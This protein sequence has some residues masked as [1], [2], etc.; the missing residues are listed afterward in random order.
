VK[1]A[2]TKA[3]GYI[4]ITSMIVL[5]AVV[6]S[7]GLIATFSAIGN[8][9]MALGG[10]QADGARALAESCMEEVLLKINTTSSV[11]STVNTPLGNCTVTTDAQAGSNYTVS[12]TATK[13]NRSKKITTSV[14]RTTTVSV[15]SWLEQN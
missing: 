13:D 10:A 14:S 3:N 11:P 9:Q 5:T 6:V 8:A 4:A 15:T 1:Y 7:V 2:Q 12:V